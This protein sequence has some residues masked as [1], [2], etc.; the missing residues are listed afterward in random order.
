[1]IWRRIEPLAQFRDLAAKR[2]IDFFQSLPLRYLV[3]VIPQVP[4]PLVDEFGV[5]PCRQLHCIGDPKQAA[6]PDLLKI[7]R[8]FH[9][10]LRNSCAPEEALCGE[11]VALQNAQ[12]GSSRSST[13]TAALAMCFGISTSL[14]PIRSATGNAARCDP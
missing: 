10:G 2:C 3:F 7:W 11:A 8:L 14:I 4:V 9:G 12:R 13:N 6:S 1:M 5:A